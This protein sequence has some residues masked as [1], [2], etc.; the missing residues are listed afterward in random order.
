MQCGETRGNLRQNA[1]KAFLGIN[2]NSILLLAVNVFLGD[3]DEGKIAL[4][5]LCKLLSKK[6]VDNALTHIYQDCKVGLCIV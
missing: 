2:N 6:G 3:S 5:I 4:Y 1:D